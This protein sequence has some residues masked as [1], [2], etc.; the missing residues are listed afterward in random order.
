MYIDITATLDWPVPNYVNPERYGPSLFIVHGVFYPIVL[1]MLIP[2]TGFAV[3][4]IF[5][6]T[7]V[8]WDVHAWDVPY[9]SL[10]LG[11]KCIYTTQILFTLALTPIRISM[12]WL[13]ARLFENG[14]PKLRRVAQG[15]MIYMLLHG[16]IFAI[17]LTFQC[18]PVSDYWAVSFKPQPNCINQEVHL[19]FTAICNG[20]SDYIVV[21]L[22]MHTVWK[23]QLP[24]KQRISLCMLFAIGFIASTASIVRTVYVWYST[25]NYDRTWT[26]YPV[27]I[28]SSVELY[29]GLFCAC[30]PPSVGF[31]KLYYPK[32]VGT[33]NRSEQNTSKS[34]KFWSSKSGSKQDRS[35]SH[36]L[37]DTDDEERGIVI[38]RGVTIETYNYAKDESKGVQGSCTVIDQSPQ[39][40]SFS[41]NNN[42]Q[43]Y[44]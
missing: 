20:I 3:V 22:P 9:D 18:R 11:L 43:R 10:T 4:S 34:S 37:A 21:I 1:A 19:L 38:E 12:L 28:W 36:E 6:E 29:L 16:S 26:A 31:W 23:L 39:L 17:T 13:I 30:T 8:G 27:Y 42:H 2:I 25:S 40:P 24:T 5:V 44:L 15:V 32:L 7:Y 14:A 35:N 41:F 33:F